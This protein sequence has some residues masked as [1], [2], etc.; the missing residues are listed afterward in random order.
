[1]KDY[2]SNKQAMTLE[3]CEIKQTRRGTKME[4]MLR[5]T[6]KL[7]QSPKTVEVSSLD[8]DEDNPIT[9]TLDQLQSLN[10]YERV[11]DY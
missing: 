1:M 2:L 10:A 8:Y 5:G 11:T 7:N 9:V 3:D 6:M 4:I